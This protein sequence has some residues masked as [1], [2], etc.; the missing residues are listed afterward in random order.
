M[1]GSTLRVGPRGS[2]SALWVVAAAGGEAMVTKVV[3]RGAISGLLVISGEAEATATM[4][5]I[6]NDLTPMVGRWR[7]M[8]FE[9]SVE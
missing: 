5:S 9:L 2:S 3:P 8:V 7:S 1:V 4:A 6:I